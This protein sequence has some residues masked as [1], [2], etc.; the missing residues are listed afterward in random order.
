[1]TEY[2]NC[3]KIL[4]LFT[5]Y[6][7]NYIINKGN[8]FKFMAYKI[9][10]KFVGF[11]CYSLMIDEIEIIDVFTLKEFRRKNIMTEMF[12]NLFKLQNIKKF[13]LEVKVNN[14]PAIN[15]YKKLG[16]E[17]ANIRKGYYNGIDGYLMIKE[18]K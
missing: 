17:I 1:M 5:E 3:D 8:N 13:I 11:I 14:I 2:V 16:F 10:D 6:K 4:N 9:D 7:D 12:N 18:M 15:L